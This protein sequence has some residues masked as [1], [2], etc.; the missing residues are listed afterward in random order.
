MSDGE[1]RTWWIPPDRTAGPVSARD[2]ANVRAAQLHDAAAA[3]APIPKVEAP[4][5]K[6]KR[7]TS[8]RVAIAPDATAKPKIAKKSKTSSVAKKKATKTT[9][10]E[11]AALGNALSKA[12]AGLAQAT[13]KGQTISVWFNR[14]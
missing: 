4:P 5:S 6:K 12:I 11:A 13:P 8:A 9:K 14:F 1:E 2:A 3:H 7:A 10:K